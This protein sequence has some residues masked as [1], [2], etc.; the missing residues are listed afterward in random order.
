MHQPVD[1]NVLAERS[2]ELD[3]RRKII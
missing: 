2:K 3:E 1:E